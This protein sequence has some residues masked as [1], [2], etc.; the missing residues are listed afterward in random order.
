MVKKSFLFPERQLTELERELEYAWAA[1]FLDGEG[2][3]QIRCMR[4]TYHVFIAAGG[5]HKASLENFKLSS[6]RGVSASGLEYPTNKTLH[7]L[8]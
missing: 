3:F 8:G 5:C 2:C 7:L 4:G 1:G 6:G